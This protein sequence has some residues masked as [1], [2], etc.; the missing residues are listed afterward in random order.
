MSGEREEKGEVQIESDERSAFT[1]LAVAHPVVELIARVEEFA[2]FASA[3]QVERL[4]FLQ[5]IDGKVNK[6][7][8]L[9]LNVIK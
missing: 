1:W 5:S 4:L 2:Y 9:A 7:N 6:T 3:R 8:T